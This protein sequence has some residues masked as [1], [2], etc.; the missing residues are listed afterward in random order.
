M[1]NHC[2]IEHHIEMI[3]GLHTLAHGIIISNMDMARHRGLM[4][5]LIK[6]N[7][8]LEKLMD[9]V[10]MSNRAVAKPT[11]VSGSMVSNMARV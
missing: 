5:L 1:P 2:N 9:K 6:A 11:M 4:V 8:A 7:I 3:V 10:N